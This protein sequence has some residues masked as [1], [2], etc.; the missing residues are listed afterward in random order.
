MYL[1]RKLSTPSVP[2]VCHKL[3]ENVV[4]YSHKSIAFSSEEL[5]PLH[6]W[7]SPDIA[8]FL[9]DTYVTS[10]CRRKGL[11]SMHCTDQISTVQLILCQPTVFIWSMSHK[12]CTVIPPPPSGFLAIMELL[13]YQTFNEPPNLSVI[14]DFKCILVIQI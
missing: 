2:L 7:D 13:I 12:A 11:K 4:E 5:R 10:S 6:V 1:R 3:L 9:T 8:P 14:I